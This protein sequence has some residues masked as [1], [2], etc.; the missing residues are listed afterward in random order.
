MPPSAPH[1]FRRDEN[2]VPSSKTARN[3]QQK[4][5]FPREKSFSLSCSSTAT[6]SRGVRWVG[7]ICRTELR[8]ARQRNGIHHNG[9]N[10]KPREVTRSRQEAGQKTTRLLEREVGFLPCSS[11]ATKSRGVRWVGC[12]CR[13]ELRRARQTTGIP[14]SGTNTKLR[15]VTRSRQEVG[16]KTAS[17][18]RS[19]LF[20]MLLY[21]DEK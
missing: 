18:E 5:D 10:T 8:R 11:T 9:T 3:Q 20:A 14:H 12:I 2:K 19:R 21:C 16:K 15:E 4:S 6:E 17:R 7:C 13:T 1:S